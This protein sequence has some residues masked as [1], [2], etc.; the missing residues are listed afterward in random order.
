MR[1]TSLLLSLP[2]NT[3]THIHKQN[4]SH[5]LYKKIKRYPRSLHA[6]RSLWNYATNKT[7]YRNEHTYIHKNRSIDIIVD[8]DKLKIYAHPHLN[9]NNNHMKQTLQDVC[10]SAASSN[11][12]TNAYIQTCPVTAATAASSASN[13][14]MNH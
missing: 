6:L 7:A 2:T 5:E 9:N 13:E 14:I 11:T 10:Q 12:E 8:I 3:H 1:S 4:Y